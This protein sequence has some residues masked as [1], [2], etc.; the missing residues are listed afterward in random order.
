MDKLKIG[1][2]GLPGV[3][4]T[5]FVENLRA[6]LLNRGFAFDRV[7]EWHSTE[8][9]EHFYSDIEKNAIETEITLL[10]HR[11]IQW[12]T[13]MN[14]CNHGVIFDRTLWCSAVFGLSTLQ[15]SEWIIY[16]LL[17]DCLSSKIEKPDVFVFLHAPI[18]VIYNRVIQRSLCHSREMESSIPKEYLE[19]LDKN[20]D[21]V[22][23]QLARD[24]PSIPIL[25]LDWTNFGDIKQV[26]D[27]ISGIV[28]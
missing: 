7:A 21:V 19:K 20:H 3:G 11:C 24:N 4:K 25:R 23:G 18:D 16:S 9:M 14:N 27:Q 1:V 10:G 17:F 12:K 5:T 2:V 13:A 22:F 26:V 8:V 6:E 28:K 15:S